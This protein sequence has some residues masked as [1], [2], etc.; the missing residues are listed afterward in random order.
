MFS[1]SGVT[2]KFLVAIVLA[3]LAIQTG[4]GAI[5]LI[6]SRRSQARQTEKFAQQMRRIQEEEKKLLEDE[7]IEKEAGTAALL[8]QIAATYIVG[9]DF[10]S[11]ATLAKVTME[12]EEFVT[13]NFYGTD[14][15]P[16]T[17]ELKTDQEVEFLEHPINFDGSPVGKLVV[18][19]SHGHADHVYEDVK[20][21]IDTM[22]EQA[23]Q[24]SHK[25]AWSLAYWISGISLA[26]LVLLAGLTWFLLA[27]II[28]VP[29]NRVV[30]SLSDSSL[31]LTA[32]AGQVSSS[33][34]SLSE[35]T[36]SQASALQETSASLEQLAAGTRQ[37]SEN[38]EQASSETNKAQEAAETGREAMTRMTDAIEKIKASSD[39]TSRIINTIDEIAFQTNLLALNAAVEAAR[40]G[41]AG[42]GFAVVAEEVRNLAGRS[43]EAAK[44]TSAL[45]DESQANAD[46]GVAMAREMGSILDQIS[47][48]VQG[49][50][51]LVGELTSSAAEQSRGITQINAAVAQIDQVTQSSS[52]SADQSAQASRAMSQLA[53]GLNRMVA[54]LQEIITGHS[55][56]LQKMDCDRLNPG[57]E[58]AFAVPPVTSYQ[59]TATPL[60]QPV[61]QRVTTSGPEVVIPLDEED[62]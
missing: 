46:Q 18:G 32:S 62:F 50:A 49:A 53:C 8:S 3:I 12:D 33:S 52:A 34:E 35:G 31:K 27:R 21:G 9:Y 6:Q 58:A 17:E 19:L 55:D 30:A 51:A 61:R 59:T 36:T 20:A 7:L 48:R 4:S 15:R 25:A 5:S 44:N 57:Y 45:I 56:N 23:N 42:K 47:Q 10:E 16:L 24:D 39:Q 40:A 54:D 11:L 14:G 43:A 2:A 38:A 13:V 29:V 41:D 37:N 1:K 22:V 26:G 60:R 28:T